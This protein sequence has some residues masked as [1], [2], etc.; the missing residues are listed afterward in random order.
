MSTSPP[1]SEAACQSR[2][3]AIAAIERALR[4][5]D[6]HGYR[7]AAIDLSAALDRLQKE[8]PRAS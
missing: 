3:D 8:E 7:R 2:E 1:Q 4:Y 6:E 5:C